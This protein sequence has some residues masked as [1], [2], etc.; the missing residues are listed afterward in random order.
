LVE[1]GGLYHFNIFKAH[2]PQN[3]ENLRGC[4]ID[5]GNMKCPFCK[6]ETSHRIKMEGIEGKIPWMVC[7]ECGFQCQEKDYEI[8]LRDREEK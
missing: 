8:E 2:R 3:F 1:D 6:K 7:N 5:R 4:G